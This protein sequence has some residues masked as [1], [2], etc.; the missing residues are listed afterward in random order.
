MFI[1]VQINSLES[2]GQCYMGTLVALTTGM[3]SSVSSA[4]C[5][6]VIAATLCKNKQYHMPTSWSS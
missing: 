4:L 1:N 5:S 2:P 3:L 6:R